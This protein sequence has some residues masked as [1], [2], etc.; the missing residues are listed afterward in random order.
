MLPSAF[1]FVDTF[2]LTQ[3]GKLDRKALPPPARRSPEL[4]N[5]YVAPGTPT[6]EVLATIWR[7]VLNLEQVGIHDNFFQLG[8]HSLLATRVVSRLRS[9]FRMEFPLRIIFENPSVSL[10]AKQIDLL[11]WAK[12]GANRE[13]L[14]SGVLIVEGQL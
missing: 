1:V 12:R 8:G 3:N 14:G 2:P 11:I 7:G 10:L 6:E 4:E 5:S 9:E 13:A